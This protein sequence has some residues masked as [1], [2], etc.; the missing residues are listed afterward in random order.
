MASP[1]DVVT[2]AISS[3]RPRSVGAEEEAFAKR[4]V[5]ACGPVSPVRA[6]SL[7]WA[8]SRLATFGAGIGLSPSEGDL[9]RPGVIERFVA[10]GM[11]GTNSS[12]RRTV[13]AN[14]RFVG[15]H[16][17]PVQ[18]PPD[19]V[20]VGRLFTGRPYSPGEIA[21]YLSLAAAQ[22]TVARRMRATGLICLAAGAGLVG[23]DLRLVRGVDV[24]VTS[25][26]LCVRVTGLHPRLVPVLEPYREALSCSA[27]FAGDGFLV[28]GVKPERHNVTHRLVDSLSG[29]EDLGRLS[30]SSLR[31]SWLACVLSGIGLPELLAA[32]GLRDSKALFDLVS[33]LPPPDEDRVVAVIG[34]LGAPKP[35]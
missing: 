29:G 22:P 34:A 6:R 16:V 14:L 23:S 5:L 13:R 25:G 26:V 31:A 19:P 7:L 20:P 15:R 3:W 33:Y 8:T 9:L 27:S 1:S 12:R 10:T 4:V 30:V 35:R 18:F 11:P 28:G 17:A 32:A 24:A 2:S 21:G